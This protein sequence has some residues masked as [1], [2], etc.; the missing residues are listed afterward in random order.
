MGKIIAIIL[1]FFIFS[2][3]NVKAI[4]FGFSEDTVTNNLV[5]LQ[6][7]PQQQVETSVFKQLEYLN[8]EAKK[9]N[10]HVSSQYFFEMVDYNGDAFAYAPAI[11]RENSLFKVLFCSSGISNTAWDFIR[12]TD[13]NSWKYRKSISVV[14]MPTSKRVGDHRNRSTCDPSLVKTDDGWY[15]VYFT[16]S[17][18]LRQSA[19]Y[20]ART[21]SLENRKSY[22]FYLGKTIHGESQWGDTLSSEPFPVVLPKN[23]IPDSIAKKKGWYGAGH[24][25]IVKIGSTWYMWHYDET[26]NYEKNK[27]LRIVKHSI[28]LRTSSNGIDWGVEKESFTCYNKSLIDRCINSMEVKF[29]PSTRQFVMFYIENQHTLESSLEIRTSFDGLSWSSEKVLCDDKCFPNY[30]HNLGVSSNINGHL[31]LSDPTLIAFGTPFKSLTEGSDNF[32]RPAW[33]LYGM[34]ISIGEDGEITLLSQ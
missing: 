5:R 25:A 34:Y 3:F 33:D 7:N 17:S 27:N 22:Q 23:S 30:A 28:H 16:G 10:L 32:K 31:S 29:N 20:L 24:Q 12:Y 6:E 19:I 2:I 14:L 1:S 18:D 13:S 9:P 15:Y 11:L 8:K 21:T 26:S 4:A